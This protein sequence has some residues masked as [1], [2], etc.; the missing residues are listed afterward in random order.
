M[1]GRYYLDEGHVKISEIL[2]KAMKYGPVQAGDIFPGMTAPVIICYQNKYYVRAARWGYQKKIINARSETCFDKAFFYHDQKILIPASG[3]YEWD[4]QKRKH[5]F[6]SDEPIY[7]G[8]LLNR[9][10]EFVIITRP[11]KDPVKVIHPRMPLAIAIED[12][13][14]WF[15][16]DARIII[17]KDQRPFLKREMSAELKLDPS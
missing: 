12:F 15:G 1:C 3:F 16:N 2:T 5:A 4:A 17:T 7:F 14:G 10:K 6:T 9:A 8:G 11:A 13:P